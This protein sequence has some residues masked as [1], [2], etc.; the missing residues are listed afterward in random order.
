MVQIKTHFSAREHGFKFANHFEPD[1]DVEYPVPMVGV[2]DLDKLAEGLCGGM[3]L[4]A[5]DYYFSRR[6]VPG[7]KE[8][9]EVDPRLLVYLSERHLEALPVP[10]LVKIIDW[11]LAEDR[12]VAR[13]M[14]RFEL[15]K[16]RRRL[17]KDRPALLTL[18]PPH[19]GNEARKIRQVLAVG[20]EGLANTNEFLITLYDPKEP[21]E[22]AVLQ[23]HTENSEGDVDIIESTGEKLRGFFISDYKVRKDPPKFT[24]PAGFLPGVS[25]GLA[26][27]TRPF[28]LEWPVDSRRVNQYFGENPET[29]RPFK[30]PGHEG[31]DLFALHGAN[32]YACADGEVYEAD[33][34]KDDPYGL[35]VRIRHEAPG[36]VY[37]TV[38][39]HLSDIFVQPGQKVTAG[40]RI[41]LADNSGNSFGAHLHLTLKVDGQKTPGYPAGI[42]DPWPYLKEIAQEASS[43]A[44]PSGTLIVNTTQGLNLRARADT[45]AEILAVLPA[46]EPLAVLTPEET[47]QQRVGK[48]GEWLRVKTASEVIGFVAAWFVEFPGQSFPPS[49]L[50]VYPYEFVNLRAGP[51]TNFPI[52]GSANFDDPLTVLGDGNL[53]RTKL[54]KMDEWLQVEMETGQKGFVAAWLVHKT[55]QS[56]PASGVSVLPIDVLNV[57]SE[58]GPTAHILTLV[59]PK[60]RLVLLGDVKLA[61]GKIGQES[62]W[63]NIRTP[64]QFSGYVAAWLVRKAD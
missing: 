41:G 23:I 3:C 29:Y 40:E 31:L 52:N 28:T 22:A 50:V 34:P 12:I 56:A 36:V 45:G 7:F 18:I 51:G 16:L 19:T 2:L 42:V 35:H 10:T 25:F 8:V 24:R 33:F 5:L 1:L 64:D 43:P 38:Y 9:K 49:D 53:S 57:R 14:R 63:L 58:P 11:M 21:L 32:V 48:E 30:L 26:E 4:A 62:Q 59:T 47:A 39:A 27:D 15:P 20:Y 61:I 17:E 13:R 55:G 54:G 44:F 46:G 60:D 6:S 37:H